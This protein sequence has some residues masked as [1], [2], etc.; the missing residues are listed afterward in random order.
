VINSKDKKILAFGCSVTHGC[1]LVSGAYNPDNC[2]GSFPNQLARKLN[3]PVDNRA[4]PGSSNEEILHRIY[5]ADL[6]DAIVIVCWTSLIREYWLADNT[7]WFF[8]PNWGASFHELEHDTVRIHERNPRVVSDDDSLLDQT[9]QYYDFF[10]QYKTDIKT[11]ERKFFHYHR[12]FK[13][14]M[15]S[16]NTPYIELT[17]INTHLPGV[18]SIDGAWTREGRHPDWQE[19]LAIANDLRTRFE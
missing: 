15:Q 3:I 1:E 17:C 9:S 16:T 10:M 2:A 18:T 13:L 5:D 8:I 11:Y 7:H 6:S 14:L 19:H 12:Q 4:L